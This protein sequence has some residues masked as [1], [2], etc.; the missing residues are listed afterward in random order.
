L[1]RNTK[2]SNTIITNLNKKIMKRIIL[3]VAALAFCFGVT[4]TSCTKDD[5]TKPVITLDGSATVTV[6]VGDSYTDAGATAND[7]KDG[8]IT[9]SIVT[10]DPVNT[11][12]VGTYT[13]SYNVTD[14]AGNTATEVERTVIVQCGDHFDG[15]YAVSCVITGG[16]GAPGVDYTATV[17]HSSTT[18]NRLNIANFSGW[19]AAVNAYILLDGTNITVPSQTLV[20]VPAGSEGTASGTTGTYSVSSSITISTLNYNYVYNSG[21]TDVCTETWVKQ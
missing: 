1:R 12:Q 7:D 15:T 2:I 19:G 20:G 21:G 8:D 11:N 18:Y 4:L 14:A 5:I 10:T 13:V 3:S 17:S 6:D 9:T 16:P